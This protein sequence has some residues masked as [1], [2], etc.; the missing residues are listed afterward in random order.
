MDN[1]K[2][3]AEIKKMLSKKA[4]FNILIVLLAILFLWLVIS[5]FSGDFSSN[6]NYQGT[7]D[8]KN[9][10]EVSTFSEDNAQVDGDYEKQ[11][12]AE[13][14]SILSK[15]Q[16]VGEVEVKIQFESG[17]VQVP[18]M[19][20][21]VQTSTTVEDD[22]EGGTRNITQQ[23]QGDSVVMKNSGNESEPFIIKT[24]KP[25]VLGVIIVAEGAEDSKIKYDIQVAV[26][27]LYDIG[28]DKV[29]VYSMKN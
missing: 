26:S 28:I 8:G 25:Q 12:T 13:L 15:I 10:A 21:D 11:Q 29:N 19:N 6:K 22:G 27:K 18:A 20:S 9:A 1:K 16:G 14:K 5:T 17:E 23:T 7:G 2:A 3:S 4:S 24:Y